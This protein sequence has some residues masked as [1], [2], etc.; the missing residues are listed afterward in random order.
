MKRPHQ[1]CF[2]C[3]ALNH[4]VQDCPIKIDEERINMHRNNFTNQS[5]NAQ[6][7]AQLNSNRYM[8]DVDSLNKD[9]VPGKISEQLRE[10]LGLRKNQLP[11]FIYRMRDLGYPIGWLLEAQVKN[12][13]LTLHDGEVNKEGNAEN[14]RNNF[15]VVVNNYHK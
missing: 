6:D 12:S 2:N 11:S 13:K 10:A 5:I 4:R 8:I 15:V 14:G 1:E 3:L 7:R 9:K